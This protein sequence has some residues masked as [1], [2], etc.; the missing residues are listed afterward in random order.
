M[1][2]RI[3][4][5]YT[6]IIPIAVIATILY[7]LVPFIN[8]TNGLPK[9][10]M[11]SELLRSAL[12]SVSIFFNSFHRSA[13]PKTTVVATTTPITANTSTAANIPIVATTS[14]ILPKTNV[15]TNILQP[16]FDLPETI[17][18]PPF[19]NSS[20]IGATPATVGKPDLE[21]KI[22][23]VGILDSSST[24]AHADSVKS[25]QKGAI[26]FDIKNIG[27]RV[28]SEWTFAAKIPSLDSD[29]KPESQSPLAPGEY[30]HFIMGFDNL[31]NNATNTISIIA[32]PD[33]K[34]SDDPNRKNN[35][36][37]TTIFRDY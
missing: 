27:T 18:P 10:S 28:S 22:L 3:K 11:P 36:A 1:I 21:I 4:K 19:S 6:S 31:A 9:Y 2:S 34:V 30:T 26:V 14:N 13:P 20:K 35:I 24:F 33:F 29:F 23:D 16:I 25:G 15:S 17:T 32:D 12:A 8:N 37:S 7:F 5:L